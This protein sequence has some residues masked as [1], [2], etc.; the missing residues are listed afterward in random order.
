MGFP[1]DLFRTHSLRRGAAT[2][3]YARG[4]PL[5][6]VRVFGRWASERACE[7]YI[8]TGDLALTRLR[9]SIVSDRWKLIVT[10]GSIFERVFQYIEYPSGM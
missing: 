3:L 2:A 8:K 7:S 5:T 4:Y 10:V 1:H 9:Q 6:D